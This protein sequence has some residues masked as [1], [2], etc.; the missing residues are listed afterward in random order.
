MWKEYKPQKKCQ[1]KS[2]LVK[3]TSVLKRLTA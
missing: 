3:F 1:K 2:G